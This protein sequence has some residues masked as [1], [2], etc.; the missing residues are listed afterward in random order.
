[1]TDP[2]FITRIFKIV[3]DFIS[4][5]EITPDSIISLLVHPNW[6]ED[7]QWQYLLV[8]IGLEVTY[9]IDIT[10]E[11]ILEF[12]ESNTLTIRDL[13]ERLNDLPKQTDTIFRASKIFMVGTLAMKILAEEK[14]MEDDECSVVN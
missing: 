12:E 5:D 10:D 3:F 2:D 6:E 7:Y 13:S 11:L 8:L 4:E 14:M 9:D 1:M